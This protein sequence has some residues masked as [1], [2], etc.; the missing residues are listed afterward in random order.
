[1]ALT[2]VLCIYTN[3][4]NRSPFGLGFATQDSRLYF[5][6]STQMS[7]KFIMLINVTMPTLGRHCLLMSHKKDASLI[8]VKH[9]CTGLKFCPNHHQLPYFECANSKGSDE[10]AHMPRLV[11]DFTARI[12]GKYQNLEYWL[13]SR[14]NSIMTSVLL[15]GVI[16]VCLVAGN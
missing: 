8:W 7:M 3:S 13:I 6:C 12:C 11:R 4:A 2:R 10:P 15:S 5:L 16:V 9:A 14:V 1:M